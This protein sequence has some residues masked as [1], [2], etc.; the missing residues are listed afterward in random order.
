MITYDGSD[1]E[2][3]NNI[4]EQVCRNTVIFCKDEFYG[5]YLHLCKE[6]FNTNLKI[7]GFYLMDFTNIKNVI[8]GLNDCF[9]E[10]SIVFFINNDQLR[11]I[12][13]SHNVKIKTIYLESIMKAMRNNK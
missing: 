9:D 6:P 13:F 12:H 3:L 10:D 2:E 11:S 4:F 1:L 8:I 7:R 5:G